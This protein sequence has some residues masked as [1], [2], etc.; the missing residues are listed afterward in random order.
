[1][2]KNF[3]IGD[4]VYHPS[5][6]EGVIVDNPLCPDNCRH[7]LVTEYVQFEKFTTDVRKTNL[8]KV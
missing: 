1:M 4:R 5:F 3:K 8:T 7:L 2:S 6:G